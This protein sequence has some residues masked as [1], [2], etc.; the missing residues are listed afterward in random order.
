MV[1][2]FFILL[3]HSVWYKAVTISINI[4]ALPVETGRGL[5]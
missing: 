1:F 3:F 5:Y 2:N 4:E